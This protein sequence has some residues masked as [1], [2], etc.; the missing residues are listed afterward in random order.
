MPT[1]GAAITPATTTTAT[2]RVLACPKCRT[3]K[4]SGKLSCCARGGAWFGKCGDPGDSE[5][6]YTWLEGIEA[7]ES[8]WVIDCEFAP[9][10]LTSSVTLW[11]Q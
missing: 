9:E 11:V 7:C 4:R 3:V 6:A 8:G 10:T 5:Y 1:S 2:A